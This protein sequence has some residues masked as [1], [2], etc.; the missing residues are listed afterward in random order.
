MEEERRMGR[1]QRAARWKS[2]PREGQGWPAVG[3]CSWSAL[4]LRSLGLSQSAV[5]E[6]LLDPFL[7]GARFLLFDL[8]PTQE[9]G[10]ACLIVQLE[11]STQSQ[12]R[13]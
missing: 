8:I 11:S 1:S 10:R 5:S 9:Q 2:G 4:I 6:I 7:S 3:L 13:L 12:S